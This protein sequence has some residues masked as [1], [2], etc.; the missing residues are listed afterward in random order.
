MRAGIASY[1]ASL[2]GWAAGAGSWDSVACP[3]HAAQGFQWLSFEGNSSRGSAAGLFEAAPGGAVRVLRSGTVSG[4]VRVHWQGR[5]TSWSKYLIVGQSTLE[6]GRLPSPHDTCL[7]P[8][9]V[10][11]P[12][13]AAKRAL[14]LA[15]LRLLGFLGSK[16][17]IISV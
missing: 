12:P 13:L 8:A 7:L 17:S 6:S 11:R 5:S 15:A 3:Q 1:S 16:V 4:A 9:S 14:S 10:L 2:S